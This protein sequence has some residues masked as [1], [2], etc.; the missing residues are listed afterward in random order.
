M[1]R[2]GLVI[3]VSDLFDKLDHLTEALHHLRH[4]RHE[5]LLLQVVADDELTFPFRKWSVFEN[6]ER[7]SDRI[8]LDPATMRAQYLENVGRHLKAVRDAAGKLNISHVLL[9]T[10]RPFDDALMAYLAARVGWR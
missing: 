2:R 1:N 6:L 5:V 7:A 3:L 4:R 9:N 8:K 10:S